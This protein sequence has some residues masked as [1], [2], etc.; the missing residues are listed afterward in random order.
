MGVIYESTLTAPLSV[1]GFPFDS[2]RKESR[3]NERCFRK[4]G[5]MPP[6]DGT[7]ASHQSST[8]P[9][10]QGKAPGGMMGGG[11]EKD[12]F[13]LSKN[14]LYSLFSGLFG[15]EWKGVRKGPDTS[16]PTQATTTTH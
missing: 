15:V 3:G 1:E 7:L 13:S 5:I 11:L 4:W 10:K 14:K 6:P 9:E 12:G 16:S 2:S 8:S